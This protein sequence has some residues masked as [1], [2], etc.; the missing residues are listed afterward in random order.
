MASQQLRQCCVKVG[1]I[2]VPNLP[3]TNLKAL[4]SN[5][6]TLIN[7]AS[8]QDGVQLLLLP[9]FAFQQY[10]W[11]DAM[12]DIAQ[13]FDDYPSQL[14][15]QSSNSSLN[16]QISRHSSVKFLQEMCSKYEIYIAT[17]I[18]NARGVDF[19]NTFILV[20]PNGQIIHKFDK[21]VAPAQ[22]SY[23]YSPANS[24]ENRRMNDIRNTNDH[25]TSIIVKT[26]EYNN[27]NNN[28]NYKTPN[29]NN[30]ISNYELGLAIGICGENELCSYGNHVLK[31]IK[32]NGDDNNNGEKIDLILQPYCCMYAKVIEGSVPQEVSD[33]I[34]NVMVNTCE[35]YCKYFQKPVLYANKCGYYESPLPWPAKYAI[36]FIYVPIGVLSACVRSFFFLKLVCT[37]LTVFFCF[38]FFLM[39]VT[40]IVMCYNVIA[41]F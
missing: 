40:V 21:T 36:K 5:L 28:N 15:S 29:T 14:F 22:E 39:V 41:I 20:S 16:I 12:W 34:N 30:T 3:I 23:V 24:C 19:Y 7:K 35:E 32:N 18:F 25:F 31:K 11:S 13:T 8:L 10:Q 9:E 1:C 38:L 26:D 4:E 27:N 6:E 37:I 33:A 2:Q 17:T